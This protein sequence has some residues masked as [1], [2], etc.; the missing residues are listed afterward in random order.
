MDYGRHSYHIIFVRGDKRGISAPYRLFSN[1]KKSLFETLQGGSGQAVQQIE[2]FS[3][4][5]VLQNFR[6]SFGLS[7]PF[8]QSLSLDSLATMKE[9]YRQADRYS[10]LEDNIRATT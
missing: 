7:T 2:S 3:M 6:R 10:M 4:D 9:L 8:F 5:V 1:K